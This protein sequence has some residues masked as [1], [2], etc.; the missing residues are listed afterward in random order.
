MS[1]TIK[2]ATI[3]TSII[4][5]NLLDAAAQVKGLDYVGTMSRDEQRA[6]QYTRAHGG[7]RGFTSIDDIIACD[8][9]NAVYIGS[10]NACHYKQALALI[11]AGKNVLVEK[12]ICTNHYEVQQLFAAANLH[13]IIST[14]AMR[15]IHDPSWAAIYKALPKLG[16]LRRATLRFG[17]YSS[18]YDDIRSGKESNIFDTRMASGALMDMGIYSVEVMCALF[19]APKEIKASPIMLDEKYYGQTHGP[20]DGAGSITCMYGSHRDFPG[21]VVELSYSKITDDYLPSQIEGELG[22]LTIDAI[23]NPTKAT[24]TLRGQTH[25]GDATETTTSTG[26]IVEE[27]ELHPVTNNMIYEVQDFVAMCNGVSID[28]MWGKGLDTRAA[29][30]HFDNASLDALAVTDEVRRQAGIVFT[31]DYSA[32]H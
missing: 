30:M 19:G 17:K 5:D 12:P 10:P 32:Y 18:R 6:T 29:F 4:S 15:P 20:L 9:V 31:E 28:T 2:L 8:D 22:T 14:E 13:H 26:N 16:T 3:G 24:L 27:I 23:S 1:D 25:R 21:L 11:R 7:S